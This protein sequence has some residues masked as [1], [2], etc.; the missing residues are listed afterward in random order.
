M[1]TAVK[2]PIPTGIGGVSE[3]PEGRK[4]SFLALARSVAARARVII[5]RNQQLLYD[6]N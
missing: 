3:M 4:S 6:S 2:I 1:L 5:D